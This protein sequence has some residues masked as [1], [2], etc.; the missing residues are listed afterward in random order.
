M[1]LPVAATTTRPL[2]NDIDVGGEQPAF[3]PRRGNTPAGVASLPTVRPPKQGSNAH[4]QVR[5]R[6]VTTVNIRDLPPEQQ[7]AVAKYLNKPVK[8]NSSKGPRIVRFV[9]NEA[10]AV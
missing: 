7:A 6:D 4:G 3:N 10:P 5:R 2:N 1:S 9:D 8:M